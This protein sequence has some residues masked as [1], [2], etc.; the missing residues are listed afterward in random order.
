MSMNMQLA[1]LYNS[2]EEQENFSM[3]NARLLY[4][5]IM[6]YDILYLPKRLICRFIDDEGY[7]DISIWN[8]Y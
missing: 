2:N 6:A 8:L 4:G 5:S 3:I 1:N 7:M